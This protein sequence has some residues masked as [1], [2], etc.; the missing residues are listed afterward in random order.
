M[1]ETTKSEI[2]LRAQAYIAARNDGDL[3]ALVEGIMSGSTTLLDVV[4]ALKDFITSEDDSLREKGVSLLTAIVSRMPPAIMNRHATR[5]MLEFFL[6]KLED[7]ATVIPALNGIL[8]LTVLPAFLASDAE[9]TSKALFEHVKMKAHVQSTR[10]VVFAIIDSLMAKHRETLKEMGDVFVA[11]YIALADGEK[12]PRNL[13]LS[14][15]IVRVILVEFTIDRHVDNLFDITFCYFPIT[16]TPPPDDP[17]RISAE[18]LKSSLRS[19]L[20]GTPRFGPLAIP[21]FLEKLSAGSPA[22]KRE[23]MNT[24]SLCFPVYG[25]RLAQE[26]GKQV[27]DSYKIEIQQPIDNETQSLALKATQ[28]LVTTLYSNDDPKAPVTG[29]APSITDECLKTLREPETSQAKPATLIL[30][31]LIDTTPAVGRAV[32]SASIT[33]L[34]TSFFSSDQATARPAILTALASLCTTVQKLYEQPSS[35]TYSSEMLLEAYKDQLLGAFTIELK[36][37]PSTGAALSGLH[38]LVTIDG[39]FSDEE[40]GFVVHNL[41][42]LLQFEEMDSETRTAMLNLF[43]ATTKI[44]PK[45]VEETTLPLLFALLP[46]RAP[47]DQGAQI[48]AARALSTLRTLCVAPVLFETLVIRLLTRLDLSEDRLYSLAILTTL[49]SVLEAKIDAGHVDVPKYAESLVPKLYSLACPPRQVAADVQLLESAAAIITLVT[50]TLSA[51]RQTALLTAVWNTFVHGTSSALGLPSG[52]G[53][54]PFENGASSEERN[55]VIM[56]AA[57]VIPLR[58]EVALPVEQP[59]AFL[60]RLLAWCIVGS[61]DEHQRLA[62]LRLI[63]SVLN[64]HADGLS[65]LLLDRLPIC[66]TQYIDNA[67]ATLDVRR[68]AISGWAWITKALIFR[69]HEQGMV[70]VERLFS[71]FTD[72]EIGWEAA[73]ALGTVGGAPDVLVKK[74]NAVIRILYAQRFFNAVLPRIVTG[75]KSASEAFQ[76]TAYLVALTSLIKTMPQVVYKSEM[77]K[78]MPLLIRALDLPDMGLKLNVIETLLAAAK[79]GSTESGLLSERATALVDAML[80]LIPT[81]SSIDTSVRLASLRYLGVLPAIVRYEVLHPQKALVVREL[82]KCLDDP[83]RVIRKEAVDAREKWYLYTG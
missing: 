7:T 44:S 83:R 61:A 38:Q 27:W 56:F 49:E 72:I 32:L 63:C 15:A 42:D 77:P 37:P 81:S 70:N 25:A 28:A 14:F 8:K 35:R 41:N 69:N 67:D 4:K 30:S 22:T 50:R 1:S 36:N 80:K 43:L 65:V 57:A 29:L 13:I 46:D 20:A 79:D 17:Y 55:L 33:H 10:F 18:D 31:A 3:D 58:P 54:R 26:I 19:C 74:N 11:G 64:K 5:T 21:L 62:T 75:A 47:Q 59:A 68:R 52:V 23:T 6:K 51:D 66:W 48:K 16:F 24:M 40:V 71:L 45:H 2:E 53:A 39:L 60:E 73:K 82:G 76:R 34:M 12:D 9:A 78:L